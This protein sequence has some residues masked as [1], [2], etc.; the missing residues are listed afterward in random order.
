MKTSMFT[1]VCASLV[2]GAGVVFAANGANEWSYNDGKITKGDWSIV[3]TAYDSG[4]GTVTLGAIESAAEDGVLDLREMEV[5]QD[6]TAKVIT[7]VGVGSTTGWTTLVKEFYSDTIAG[8]TTSQFKDSTVLKMVKISGDLFT[9][10]PNTCFSGCTG[11]TN[12]VMNCPNLKSY[13]TQCMMNTAITNHAREV[14]SANTQGNNFGPYQE[15]SLGANAN[16]YGEVVLTNVTEGYG[17]LLSFSFLSA[18]NFYFAGPYKGVMKDALVSGNWSA[19]RLEF[20]FTNVTEMTFT[21]G[22]MS[23]IEDIVLCAPNLTNVANNVFG[24]ENGNDSKSRNLKRLWVYGK[25]YG[26]NVV[27]NLVAAFTSIEP[28]AETG[29]WHHYVNGRGWVDDIYERG[30]LYCSKKQGWKDLAKPLTA[31]TY[32]ATHAPEGC[33]GMYVTA[34]GKRKAWMVHFPQP[35]DPTGLCIRVQ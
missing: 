11:L 35:D 17:H 12:L 10:V 18:T 31:G 7:Q 27:D 30:I 26:T 34:A 8:F 22:N 4:V 19:K 33:F 21:I 6:G 1:R 13:G 14:I 29:S 16:V 5:V 25:A 23:S 32:E 20:W 2:I 3:A 28:D 9:G 24:I 15:L